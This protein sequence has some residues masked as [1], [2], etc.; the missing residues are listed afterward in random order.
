MKTAIF[1]YDRSGIMA[2]PWLNKGYQC[3]LIDGQHEDGIHVDPDNPMLVRWGMWIDAW[4]E[5]TMVL[6]T[7]IEENFSNIKL[8]FGFPECTHLAVSGAKHFKKK[9]ESD[10]DIQNKALANALLI[11]NIGSYFD[12]PWAFE[13]PVS[14]ISTLYRKP[15]FYFH[16]YDYGGWIEEENAMHPCYPKHIAPRD[17]Y[18]KK[19]GIWCGNGFKKPSSLPVVPENGWS[20]Q[21]NML[22]GKS[23]K[24]KNIRSAT[25][26]GFAIAVGATM[27][28]HSLE[29]LENFT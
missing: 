27:A 13:N 5:S 17:A 7:K 6:I 14:I 2:Q 24:T 12:C 9:L 25:P 4:N 11:K 29:I 22:G 20:R 21:Q 19:T 3:V 26:R 8:V 23:L 28:D 16:P 1:I 18:P 10:P 15:D